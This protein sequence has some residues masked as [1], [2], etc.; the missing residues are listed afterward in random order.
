MKPLHLLQ[1]VATYTNIRRGA[2]QFRRAAVVGV[3]VVGMVLSGTVVGP[4][5]AEELDAAAGSTATPSVV[6][7]RYDHSGGASETIPE[8]CLYPPQVGGTPIGIR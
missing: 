8:R 5:L 2:E 7:V 4:V 6:E 3:L 1:K